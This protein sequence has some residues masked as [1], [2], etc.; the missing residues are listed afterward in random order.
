MIYGASKIAEAYRR[1]ST[2]DQEPPAPWAHLSDNAIGISKVSDL[3]YLHVGTFTDQAG[4]EIMTEHGI[5]TV[6]VTRVG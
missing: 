4:F 2:G 1:L 3:A 6:T 5:Y